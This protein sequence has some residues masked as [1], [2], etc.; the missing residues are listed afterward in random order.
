MAQGDKFV[1]EIVER[2]ILSGFDNDLDTIRRRQD[3]L[4]DCLNQPA[5]V[6]EV[7][8]IAV[9]A[10]ERQRKHYLGALSRYPDW[11]LR[12]SIELMESLLSI[13]RKLR[14]VADSHAHEFVS[15]GWTSSSRC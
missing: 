12:L 4:N 14:E 13:V 3:I 8:A 9:E 10:V 2:V 6:R 1:L 15:D 11:V 5:I 7:Y